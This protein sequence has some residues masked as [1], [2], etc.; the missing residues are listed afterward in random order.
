MMFSFACNMYS[1][2][3]MHAAIVC[4]F[5]FET[6]LA[7]D[8]KIQSCLEKTFHNAFRFQYRIATFF[9]QYCTQHVARKDVRIIISE[10]D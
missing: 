9:A 10:N 2:S 6:H 7:D 8:T 5:T 3:C 4:S 1:M